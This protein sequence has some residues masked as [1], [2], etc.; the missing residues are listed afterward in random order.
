[1]ETNVP[2]A[3]SFATVFPTDLV[4]TSLDLINILGVRFVGRKYVEPYDNRD[5]DTNGGEF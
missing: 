1:M 2:W 3:G 5:L 4:V